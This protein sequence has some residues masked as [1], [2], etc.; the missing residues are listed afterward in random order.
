M[1]SLLSLGR[2]SKNP[3]TDDDFRAFSVTLKTNPL[4]DVQVT[5]TSASPNV[6]G[7]HEEDVS[8]RPAYSRWIRI[9]IV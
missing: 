6:S 4:V 8:F 3:I 2:G 1:Q 7:E 9:D 5:L